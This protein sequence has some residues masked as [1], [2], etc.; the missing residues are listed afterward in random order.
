MPSSWAMASSNSYSNLDSSAFFWSSRSF[1]RCCCSAR[2]HSI[3]VANDCSAIFS[4]RANFSACYFFLKTERVLEVVDWRKQSWCFV[5]CSIRGIHLSA[6]WMN[7]H[8]F[9]PHGSVIIL[10][11][12]TWTRVTYIL[13][14]RLFALFRST[15][16]STCVL[17]HTWARGPWQRADLSIHIATHKKINK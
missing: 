8:N 1:A 10:H 2:R 3:S 9:K 4:S 7:L 17:S 16:G 6:T 14:R 12:V 15:S 11:A 13:T 5:F